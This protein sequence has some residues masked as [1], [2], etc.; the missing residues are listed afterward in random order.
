MNRARRTGLVVFCT[1]VTLL[2]SVWAA[3]PGDSGG[4]IG[5]ADFDS[6]VELRQL[7]ARLEEQ[8]KQ[9]EELRSAL[10]QQKQMLEK[11]EGMA[12]AAA[13]QRTN[14]AEAALAA[15]FPSA[16]GNST[17]AL[18]PQTNSLL[19]SPGPQDQAAAAGTNDPVQKAI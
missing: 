10:N 13:P 4:A 8:Q 11:V 16:A 6:A 9:I 1:S 19:P 15:A 18:Q 17:A 14:P 3:N 5:A 12:L 7:K 2:Q